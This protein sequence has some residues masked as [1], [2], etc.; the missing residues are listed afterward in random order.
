MATSHTPAGGSVTIGA[1]AGE[2]CAS[3]EASDTGEGMPKDVQMR[4]FDR[5]YRAD[6]AR[7]ASSGR[8][9]LGLPIAKSII[10]LHGGQISIASRPNAGTKVT[11]HLTAQPYERVIAL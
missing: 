1:A 11:I 9:G 8:L 7:S 3:I 2:A 10:D 6:A 4:V 5:F